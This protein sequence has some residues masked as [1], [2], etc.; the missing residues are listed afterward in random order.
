VVPASSLIRNELNW[1]TH[2]EEQ[3]AVLRGLMGQ[4]GLIDVGLCFIEDGQLVLIDG[5]AR[6]DELGDDPMGVVVL[7]LSREEAN[8]ALSTLDPVSA[9]AGMDRVKLDALLREVQSSDQA[10]TDM[11]AS[12]AIDAG[13]IPKEES[14]PAA[15]EPNPPAYQI[16]IDFPSEAEQG[17][18]LTKLTELGYT[19]KSLIN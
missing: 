19:C 5:H 1:R 13:I 8:L 4:L 16:L 2:G 14:V 6:A 15:V 17:E 18:A 3:L 11:L 9:M 12:L 7:D 10:V